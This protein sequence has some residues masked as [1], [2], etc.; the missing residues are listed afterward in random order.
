MDS[1]ASLLARNDLL[2]QGVGATWTPGLLWSTVGADALIA[3]A[4][5]AMTMTVMRFVRARRDA[6]L[7]PAAWLFSA[8][9]MACAVTYAIDIWAVWHPGHAVHAF[10]RLATAALATLTAGALWSLIPKALKTPSGPQLRA[11]VGSLEAQGRVPRSA[12]DRLVELQQTLAV[13]LAS[14]DAG[15][16]ATD[17]EGKV[18]HMNAVAQRVTGWPL[19]EAIGKSLWQVLDREDRPTSY[20]SRNPVDVMVEQGPN[21]EVAQY[22]VAISRQGLRTAI[23][24][25]AALTRGEDASVRGLALVFRDMTEHMRSEVESSRLAA[26]VESSSDAIIGKTLDGR[27]T[28]WN[29]AARQL[30]GYSAEEAIGQRVQMLIPSDREAEEMGILARLASGQRITAFDTVRRTKAGE[31]IDVSLAIS[32]IH[33]A[34]GRIVG[35]SKI[36]R[37]VTRQRRAEAA[38]RESEARLRFTL[39]SAQIGDWE[40]DPAT[41]QGRR[42]IR[43]DRCFGYTELQ[44]E[45]NFDIFLRH[46]HPDDRSTL[47]ATFHAAVEKGKDWHFDCRVIWPDASEHW[48]SGNASTQQEAGRPRRMLGI[49]MDVTAQRLAEQARITAQRL[50]VENRQIQAANRLKSQF[51]ANMSHELRTPLNAIIGFAD[52][53]HAGSVRPESP[54]HQKFLG[55]IGTSGRHLLQLINDVLDLSK[56]ESGKFEFFPEPVQLPALIS[57]A[58]DVLH[59]VMQNKRIEFTAEVDP[60]LTGLVLDPARFKQLLYN[61][62]SNAIKFSPEG[63]RVSVRAMA[64]GPDHFRLEVEDAGIG[65]AE[66]DL[67]RL[68]SEFEQLD[69]GYSKH[70]Q[71]TGLGLS[72]TRR[73]VHAQGG[74]VGVRSVLGTGSVFHLVLARVQRTQ[75]AVSPSA[76]L[77]LSLERRLLVIENW[78]EQSRL[79]QPLRDAGFAV[80]A[81]FTGAQAQA[82]AKARATAYSAITLDLLLPDQPGLSVLAHIRAQGPSR[83]SPVVG[84]TMPADHGRAA[85]FSIADVLSKPIRTDEVVSAMARFQGAARSGAKVMVIDD[86]PLAL[87]L[88][89]ASLAGMGIAAVCMPD[90]HTALREI[91]QHQPD[92]IILDLMMPG[93][94]GFEVLDALRRLPHFA[95][96]PVF[97]WTSMIL[98]DDEYASLSRSARAILGK[99]GGGMSL[100]LESLRRWNPPAAIQR[101]RS[102]T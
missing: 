9:I 81:A 64:E 60:T 57:E 3:A 82:L 94:D 50:E 41:Q 65:I 14:I 27:I 53:L 62:L 90:G 10:S 13:T 37:D 86:D 22:V 88:M 1:L 85:T 23:E 33:D 89:R 51:L 40:F 93:F 16:V 97:I 74:S 4:C 48:I 55:H 98:T 26:I 59:A 44:P 77:D 31:L 5:V 49:V 35:A 96:L 61:Y 28:S 69:A 8:F 42:S 68:F 6:S 58:G 21:V 99:G 2:P 34:A 20:A 70:H 72:L 83:E 87:D 38:L 39:E 54:Q 79:V 47:A 19:H 73:L 84:V 11:A 52:L 76:M 63:G 101:D 30:F 46:V 18:T 75:A 45:W 32:P 67:P 24:V 100:V 29:G 102:E 43:H 92:A 15:F 7:K 66:V 91:D 12:E 71:G 25:R 36:L 80:D 95:Q 17:R 56:I 78:G